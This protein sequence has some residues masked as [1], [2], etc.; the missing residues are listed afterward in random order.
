MSK[1]CGSHEGTSESDPLYLRHTEH[2]ARTFWLQDKRS[3]PSMT[4]E[5]TRACLVKKELPV[6]YI[7]F[8]I[9]CLLNLS[10]IENIKTI[11]SLFLSH[12]CVHL[13]WVAAISQKTAGTAILAG[14]CT[15]KCKEGVTTPLP[16]QLYAPVYGQ[17]RDTRTNSY[18]QME[19][20]GEDVAPASLPWSYWNKIHF[21]VKSHHRLPQRTACVFPKLLMAG[22]LSFSHTLWALAHPIR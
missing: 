4:Y 21:W 15:N 19:S 6:Q 13:S 17:A 12:L 2:N 14:H 20:T 10:G 7:Y 1:R 16:C 8:C 18:L 5:R 3:L 9:F 11:T 22:C